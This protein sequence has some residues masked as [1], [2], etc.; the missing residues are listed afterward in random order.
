MFI[1]S[2]WNQKNK[3]ALRFS[4]TPAVSLCYLLLCPSLWSFFKVEK[5]KRSE[6]DPIYMAIT[7]VYDIYIYIYIYAYIHIYTYTRMHIYRHRYIHTYIYMVSYDTHIY[8]YMLTY[9]YNYINN[10]N[11]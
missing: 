2:D 5:K 10:Y 6:I 9:I 4:G 3:I 1:G 11:I 8:I 7:C